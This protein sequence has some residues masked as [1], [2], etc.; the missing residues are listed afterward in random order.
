[1][2]GGQI[3]SLISLGRSSLLL[4]G[5]RAGLEVGGCGQGLHAGC[6]GWDAAPRYQERAVGEAG[7]GSSSWTQA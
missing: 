2:Q 6:T 5:L 7:P 1:M 4:T 3:W